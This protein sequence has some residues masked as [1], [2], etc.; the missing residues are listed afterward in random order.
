[1]GRER[2]RTSF[3]TGSGYYRAS[4]RA[5]PRGYC[6]LAGHLPPARTCPYRHKQLGGARCESLADRSDW[7][8]S[9]VARQL[10]APF[11]ASVTSFGIQLLRIL[12][13][14]GQAWKLYPEPSMRR[15]CLKRKPP[16]HHRPWHVCA[17]GIKSLGATASYPR[18]SAAV[19]RRL[20]A[21]TQ[22]PRIAS[23]LRKGQTE[24]RHCSLLLSKKRL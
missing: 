7:S 10:F 6:R 18:A 14:G 16:R 15:R 12:A 9:A 5:M 8:F 17:V 19:G 4:D 1:V 24:Q 13:R 23:A 2:P 20:R 22:R 3:E 11:E 21:R